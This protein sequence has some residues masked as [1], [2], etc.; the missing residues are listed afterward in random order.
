MRALLWAVTTICC[1]GLLTLSFLAGSGFVA[2]NWLWVGFFGQLCTLSSA[3][4]LS[5]S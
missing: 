5:M 4:W 2:E 1:L 3:I